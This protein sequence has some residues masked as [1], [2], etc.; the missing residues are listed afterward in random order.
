MGRQAQF[1][2][3]LLHTV[4]ELRFRTNELLMVCTLSRERFIAFPSESQT[5]GRLVNFRFAAFS[6]LLQTFKDVLPVVAGPEFIWPS[7][8][9]VRHIA[10][11]QSIRNAITHDGN[12]VINGW[13]EGRFY[14]ISD[15][16]RI[17]QGGRPVS[18]TAP[19]QDIGTLALEFTVDFATAIQEH[20]EPLVGVP[21]LSEPLYGEEFFGA[22]INHPAV[23]A[24]AKELVLAADLKTT[25]QAQQ[26]PVPVVQAELCHLKSDCGFWALRIA[27]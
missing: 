26:G 8:A 23:P 12:P 13:I 21:S 5:N 15:F 17:G 16:I 19:V 14:V 24:F 9:G 20:V 2:H 3:A 4:R 7:M 1:A 22:A 10:F 6:S 18:V 11:M 25:S 27:R